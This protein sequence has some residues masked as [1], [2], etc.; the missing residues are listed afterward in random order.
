MSSSVAG[1]FF[2]SDSAY[3]QLPKESSVQGATF[4]RCVAALLATL[5]KD[6]ELS[7]AI[8]QLTSVL[9]TYPCRWEQFTTHDQE[10]CRH[11]IHSFYID[12][13]DI[14]PDSQIGS[15]DDPLYHVPIEYRVTSAPSPDHPFVKRLAAA[16]EVSIIALTH[17][18]TV[19]W[20]GEALKER[21][22]ENKGFWTDLQIIFPSM[23]VLKRLPE[24]PEV[25][26][27]KTGAVEKRTVEDRCA[28]W[29]EG[30]KSVF[31]FLLGQGPACFDRWH[32]LEYEENLPFTGPWFVR[33]QES[34]LWVQSLLPGCDTKAIYRAELFKGMD[35]Y[36]QVRS[37][38]IFIA[39]KS[40]L[41]TEWNVY[42]RAENEASPFYYAGIVNRKR[43]SDRRKF[44]FPTVL[45]IL[46]AY[47]EEEG[48][49]KPRH[50]LLLQERTIYNADSDAGKFSNISGRVTDAD[51][52]RARGENPVVF[53]DSMP[54]DEATKEFEK[55][56]SL[57]PDEALP[58][59]TWQQAAIREIQEE[60]GISVSPGPDRLDP[61]WKVMP[62]D[63]RREDKTHMLLYFNIFSLRLSRGRM[64]P[65][66]VQVGEKDEIEAIRYARPEA[67]L[68]PFGLSELREL[69][70]E[71]KLNH[72][73]NE[74]FDDFMEIF[75]ELGID[76]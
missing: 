42:G 47:V 34:S 31:T 45:V 53:P 67:N 16:D 49:S 54:D 15:A 10:K 73:L 14:S 5:T 26:N 72:L 11:D 43:L 61:V 52:F 44:H 21:E 41:V 25:K 3:R 17:E 60:L 74:R 56:V 75:E 2:V 66:S 50:R 22:K 71:G 76:E 27:A 64:L 39:Q 40:K 36:E 30:K 51:V 38:F 6:N 28:K 65:G 59:R 13:K 37:A 7:E 70:K 20:L 1:H 12:S 57:K 63:V 32:C 69:K 35:A 18:G 4:K 33:D 23:D 68:H 19:K 29:E 46:H 48:D 55:K 9:G 24:E 58:D 8:Q 62:F